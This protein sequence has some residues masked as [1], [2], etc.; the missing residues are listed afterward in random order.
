[1]FVVSGN[2][3]EHVNV[4]FYTRTVIQEG[5]ESH[6]VKSGEDVKL[7]CE[8]NIDTRLKIG[9][10]TIWL[11]DEQLLDLSNARIHLDNDGVT[12]RDSEKDDE[13]RYECQVQTEYDKVTSSGI[14][15]VL[16]EPPSIISIPNNIR[17]QDFL[18][19]NR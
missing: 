6:T 17:Y 13:G 16:N 4:E 7:H 1:M 19:Q 18:N 8:T 12:I 9:S 3:K 2:D 11:K 10:R 14:L 15:T 5:I